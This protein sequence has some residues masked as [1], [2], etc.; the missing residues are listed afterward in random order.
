[1]RVFKKNRVY[2]LCTL[3]VTDYYSQYGQ[4]KFI[5]ERIFL[6]EREKCFVDIG[7][8]DGITLSNSYY[9]EKHLGWTG[10]CV[11]PR[12]LVRGKLMACRK[13]V[14]TVCAGA[15]DEEVTFTETNHQKFQMMSGRSKYN[16]QEK[17][18]D[19]NQARADRNIETIEVI[20]PMVDINKLISKH[21]ISVIDFLSIDTEGGRMKL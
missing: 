17:M 7:A 15:C 6:N 2:N 16:V 19:W 1:M 9:F 11:E 4:D 3:G 13:N 5:A 20:Y 21:K 12:T 14:E 8:H 18:D 10:F